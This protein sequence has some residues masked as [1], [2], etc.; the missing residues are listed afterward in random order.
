[1][2][3]HFY[4]LV[5]LSSLGLLASGCSQDDKPADFDIVIQGARVV[6]PES[7]LDT[8]SN[9][10][11][12]GNVIAA[13]MP[14]DI[15]G[16][17]NI[18]A[19]GLIAAPGFIDLH[20]HGQDPYSEKL[21]VLDGKTS[22]LDLEAGALPVADY[23]EYKRNKSITNYGASVGHAFARV[24]VMDGI[25]AHGIG[26]LN[27]TLEKTGKTGNKWAST[28][29]TQEQLDQIDELVI[30]GL[31]EGGLGIGITV[32]YYP[33]ARSEGL[34]RMAKIAHQHG[35]FLTTHSRYISLSQPSGMR[36]IQEMIA[37]ATSYNVPLLVHHVPTNALAETKTALDMIDSANRNG[38]NIVGEMFPYDRGST[39][40]ATEIL[41]EG[42]Q[43]RMAMDY[44]DLTWVETGE[45]LTEETF[46]KYRRERP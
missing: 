41:S 8:V 16:R 36:G 2:K 32:G 17:E 25:N 43:T 24:R 15:S 46:N 28:L 7:G 1:M 39:F 21:G 44:K 29:A 20:V 35:T 11:I 38:A 14:E 37:L 42:W 23:Y 13:I 30:E 12:K 10:A 27:H 18:D 33:K 45:T 31:R 9:I 40:I 4:I 5:A 19:K 34:A 3:R 26:M 22:Q 6:D